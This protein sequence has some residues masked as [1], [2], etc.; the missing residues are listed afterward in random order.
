M[1]PFDFDASPIQFQDPPPPPPPPHDDLLSSYI[2][3]DNSGSKLNSPTAYNASDTARPSH[4]RSNS[5]ETSSSLLSEGIESKKAM[6]PDK[7]AQLWTVDPKRAKRFF[8][9]FLQQ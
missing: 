6:S 4:R 9:F 2:D 7:L 3:S 5:A 1:D 8:F